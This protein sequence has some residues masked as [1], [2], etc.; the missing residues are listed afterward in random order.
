MSRADRLE[1]QSL[2][3]EISSFKI[4]LAD[5]SSNP[6]YRAMVDK[7]PVANLQ[8]PNKLFLLWST[9]FILED[10]LCIS[11]CKHYELA[12]QNICGG[13]LLPQINKRLQKEASKVRA[14]FKKLRGERKAGFESS[15]CN[16]L[17]YNSEVSLQNNT[18]TAP[19]PV[20]EKE[21][22]GFK[23][24]GMTDSII[25]MEVHV[26]NCCLHVCF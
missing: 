12:N 1:L 21:S 26:S 9:K 18:S 20:E 13:E 23:L 6:R 24:R 15:K 16:M 10:R 19:E 22:T 2:N 11:V 14:Q 4:C 3:E 5:A 8:I 25:A 7:N 17:I